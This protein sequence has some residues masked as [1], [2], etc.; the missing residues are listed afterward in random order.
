[1]GMTEFQIMMR[2]EVPLALPVII[3]GLRVAAVWIIGTAALA[4]AI[5]GGGLGRLIF[6]GL[7]AIRNEVIVA[8]AVPATLLA[9]GADYGLR[10]VQNH[11]SPDT[12]ARRIA[13]RER[14][15]AGA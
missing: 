12:R 3:G 6:S 11:L 9:L 4:A 15:T 10:A 2:V 13:A 14:R 5:G 1:M 8:G 7:S